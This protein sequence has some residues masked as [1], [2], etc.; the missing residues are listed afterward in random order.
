MSTDQPAG[1]T[2]EDFIKVLNSEDELGA[3]IRAH[4]H[5]EALLLELLRLLVKD[6]GA[7]RK[8]NLEFSQSVDLAIALGL[9]PEHAK[10]LRAF[11]KLRNE[12][13]HDL[14]SRLSDNRINN[15]YMSLSTADKEVIQHAY[16]RTNSQL[17]A[18]PPSFKDLTPK[19]KF[20]LVAVALRGMLEV[21]LS[22]VRKAEDSMQEKNPPGTI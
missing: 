22:E 6:E 13:A 3:V 21:A 14:N 16:A 15:L 10:G 7:L 20:V 19:E 9:G 11:G 17:G 4:I 12:F 8:L 2:I 5:I 18:N 1:S